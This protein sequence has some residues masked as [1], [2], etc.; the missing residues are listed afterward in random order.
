MPA[1]E[2]RRESILFHSQLRPNAAAI[3]S[4]CP[5]QHLL[6][7][8]NLDRGLSPRE[9]QKIKAIP[10]P[11]KRLLAAKGAARPDVFVLY[12][13]L[14]RVVVSRQFTTGR[15]KDFLI[16]RIWI[17]GSPRRRNTRSRVL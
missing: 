14:H 7:F 17:N 6:E 4:M 3:I 12:D 2:F 13:E 15:Y 16:L 9:P 8:N 5:R 1:W 10:R 11:V